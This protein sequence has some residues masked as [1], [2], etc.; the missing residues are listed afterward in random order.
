MKFKTFDKVLVR[1]HNDDTWK[2]A[3]YS[4]PKDKIVDVTI[5]GSQWGQCIPFEENEHLLGTAITPE[6]PEKFNFGDHVMASD[7]GEKWTQAVYLQMSKGIVLQ[8]RCVKK[9]REDGY[10]AVSFKYCRKADW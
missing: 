4:H 6:E 9:T 7:D 10:I 5:G 8:Y 2:A 3:F 1:Q